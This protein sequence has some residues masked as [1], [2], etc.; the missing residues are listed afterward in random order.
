MKK[1]L[2]QFYI[3][4]FVIYT[5]T[6][7]NSVSFNTHPWPRYQSDWDTG[8]DWLKRHTNGMVFIAGVLLVSMIAYSMYKNT[9]EQ[10]YYLKTS[11]LT[12][13]GKKVL[14]LIHQE[15]PEG[16]IYVCDVE[17]KRKV[18]ARHAKVV[19]TNRAA[20]LGGDLL[21]IDFISPV[22]HTSG[23]GGSTDTSISYSASGRVYRK[24]T[25]KN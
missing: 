2:V 9:K 3:I 11:K 12:P 7:C 23:I 21:V 14:V 5:F 22:S 4:I 10:R 19:L 17:T 18:N 6:S 16:Y 8:D 24:G 20:I 13:E 1:V 25:K 15:A